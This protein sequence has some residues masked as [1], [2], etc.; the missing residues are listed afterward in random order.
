MLG[1]LERD[2]VKCPRRIA[3]R[4]S[5]CGCHLVVC[6]DFLYTQDASPSGRNSLDSA[7][8]VRVYAKLRVLAIDRTPRRDARSNLSNDLTFE[9]SE[10]I[11]TRP[12]FSRRETRISGFFADLHGKR[13]RSSS[14][15]RVDLRHG[16]VPYSLRFRV[17]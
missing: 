17:R 10:G 6:F 5:G 1:H 12:R 3:G 11:S 2:V 7:R 9:A 14:V 4:K 8:G 16:D 13:R 15:L